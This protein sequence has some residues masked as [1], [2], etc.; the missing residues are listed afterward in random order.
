MPFPVNLLTTHAQCDTVTE[1]LTQEK[2]VLALQNET[3]DLRADQAGDRATARAAA[4]TA[5][6]ASVAKLTP[7]VAGLTEGTPEYLTLNRMLTQASRRV[8]DLST[9]TTTATDPAVAFLKAVDVRQVAVQ[10]P[11]LDG[12]LAEVAAHRPTLSA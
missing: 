2:R 4:L 9:P 11:E 5:A 7:L 6:Q 3:T 10:L 8:Q 12:A 1:A